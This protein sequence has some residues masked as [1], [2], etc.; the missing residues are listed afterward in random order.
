MAR[1]GWRGVGWLVGY[2]VALGFTHALVIAPAFGYMGYENVPPNIFL[3]IVLVPTYVLCARRLPSSWERPSTVIYWMLFL[4]VVAPVHVI[5]VF[6]SQLTAKVLLMVGAVVAAFWLLGYIY[7]VRIP[8]PHYRRPSP[9]VYWLAFALLWVALV[10]VVV[11]YYGLQLRFVALS[12]IYDVRD[13]YRDSFEYVPRAARYAITWLGNA[14]APIAIGRGLITRRWLWVVFGVLT[15]LFLVSITGF[16][17][18]LFASALVAAVVILVRVTDPKRIGGRVAVLVTTGVVVLTMVDFFRGTASLTTIAVRRLVLTAGMNTKYYFDFFTD[19]PFAFLGHGL[20][21]RW[22]EYPYHLSPPFLI[23]EVYFGDANLSA[24]ANVWA[25]AYANFGLVGV[26][27][28]T[29]VLA[30]AL[31]FVDTVAQGVTKGLAIAGLAQSAFSLSNTALPTVFLTHGMLLAIFLVAFMPTEAATDE[32]DGRR[33]GGRFPLLRP[34]PTTGV[35][36][37]SAP[38]DPSSSRPKTQGRPDKGRP[39]TTGSEQDP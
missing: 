2:A 8:A 1:L 35:T 9:R 28:Y 38:A 13:T 5:P 33:S 36:G 12:E 22:V 26:L 17:Q 20:F 31:L 11:S 24:N 25:D 29:V 15:E 34:R 27:G 21:K 30:A 7:S 23:G 3:A 39:T 18:M 16:K 10:G 19:H 14:I 37:A 32:D 6:T 4:L